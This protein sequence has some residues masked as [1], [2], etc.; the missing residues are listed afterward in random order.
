MKKLNISTIRF[1]FTAVLLTLLFNC[2]S[3]SHITHQSKPK[4]IILFIC[5]GWGYNHIDV[6]NY[7]QFGDNK[8]QIYQ[9]FPIKYAVSTFSASSKGYDP[10][11]AWLKKD[12]INIKP[13]GSAAASTAIATGVKTY[14]G[15][16]GLNTEN[17]HIENI[18]ERAKKKGKATGVVTSVQFSHAT[19][20]GFVA[21]HITR[22]NYQEISQ[23]MLTE[24]QVDVIMGCGHPYYNDHGEIASDTTFQYVGGEKIW[25]ALLNNKAFNDADQDGIEDTWYI[26]QS[27]EDFL[28][29]RENAFAKR[30]LGIPMVRSTLQ[31]KRKG[32][33]QSLPFEDPYL[34]DIP[35]L[36][37]M[38]MAAINILSRDP[39]GFFLM[40]E[41]GAVD[42]ASHDNH[43]TRMIEEMIDF[44]K[45]VEKVVNWVDLKS[46]W[47]ETLLIV[48][49]DHE[50][51]YLTG[52]G[53][54]NQDNTKSKLQWPVIKNN[55]KGKLPG[56]EW[57]SGYHTN[58]LIP[59][60]AKGVGQDEFHLYA[61]ESDPVR[62]KY[63]DNAEIGQIL[64][65]LYPLEGSNGK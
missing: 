53:F 43:S 5:D 8:N 56:M 51:G 9:H 25:N 61:N 28:K 22:N 36:A 30:V 1:L 23:Q 52:P 7:Y 19:P 37:E 48:T 2:Q 29:L 24:S 41:A 26:V 40:I 4:N 10:Q 60:F 3:Q 38:S 15:V 20:A 11:Q 12:Y 47:Q 21:H 31:Y 6:T 55:G 17:E 65:D 18:C 16:I 46:D 45:A 44:N 35:S 13:T 34:E 14:N 64:F 32:N 42:W 33:S 57:Q 39:D 58:S 62:G 63:L 49:G 54:S 50:C 27:R 59:L